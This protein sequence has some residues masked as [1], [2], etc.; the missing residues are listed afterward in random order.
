MRSDPFFEYSHVTVALKAL[1]KGVR[2]KGGD[3]EE[4]DLDDIVGKVREKH[5]KDYLERQ[6]GGEV[7][8]S[9]SKSKGKGKAKAT[10]DDSDV[11]M[12]SMMEEVDMTGA[13]VD[14]FDDDDE[15]DEPPP[16]KKKPAARGRGAGAAAK[17]APTKSTAKS[18]ATG[19]GRGKKKVRLFP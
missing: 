11:S 7:P 17:K 12:D 13:M 5:E 9:K 10:G 1:M 4:D 16:T 15:E 18:T 8:D 2:A 6:G 19:R 14:D 3:F